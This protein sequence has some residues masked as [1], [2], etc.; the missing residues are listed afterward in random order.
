MSGH[1]RAWYTCEVCS[2]T[3]YVQRNLTGLNMSTKLLL[4][5]AKELLHRS[6][7]LV[8]TIKDLQF[9]VKNI[10]RDHRK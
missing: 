1:G 3:G 5:S 6:E 10:I 4:E 7:L 8:A 2:G 9:A